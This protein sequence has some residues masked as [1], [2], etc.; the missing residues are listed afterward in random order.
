MRSQSIS[1]SKVSK[2]LATSSRE[3]PYT[4]PPST[5]THSARNYGAVQAPCSTASATVLACA[6]MSASKYRSMQLVSRKVR[7]LSLQ[8]AAVGGLLLVACGDGLLTRED[9]HRLGLCRSRSWNRNNH[10]Q[11][12]P[13]DGHGV[14]HPVS[15]T[16]FTR[17]ERPDFASLK[18][19]TVGTG[20]SPKVESG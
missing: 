15:W 14:L 5:Y 17:A 11:W 9:S 7:I 2:A 8:V 10:G 19:I 18:G 20:S 13:P 16:L 6:G 4:D 3:S 1:S 12:L